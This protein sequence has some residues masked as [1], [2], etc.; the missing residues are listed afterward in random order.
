[1]NGVVNDNSMFNFE[2]IDKDFSTNLLLCSISF[3]VSQVIGCQATTNFILP[4]EFQKSDQQ[5]L[6]ALSKEISMF[7]STSADGSDNDDD[8]KKRI[9]RIFYG[10]SKTNEY[11]IN[12]TYSESTER[13]SGKNSIVRNLF[14]VKT[15]H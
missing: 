6:E 14:K 7:E 12:L 15:L 4:N 13:F 10:S 8:V 1:M 11:S 2:I 3:D 5:P 9:D